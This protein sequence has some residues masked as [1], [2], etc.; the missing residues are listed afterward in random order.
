MSETTNKTRAN[1]AFTKAAPEIQQLIRDVL[2]EEREMIN[3][4]VRVGIHNKLY[5]HIRQAIK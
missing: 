1:Q 3:M 5:E 4:E 2:R